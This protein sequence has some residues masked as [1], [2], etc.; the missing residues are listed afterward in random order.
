[1]GSDSN[2]LHGSDVRTGILE[3][4]VVTVILSA[5]FD[6]TFIALSRCNSEFEN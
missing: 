4:D 5:L 3:L 1:M 6:T 2:V